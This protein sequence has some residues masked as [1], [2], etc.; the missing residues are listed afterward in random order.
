MEGVDVKAVAQSSDD[1]PRQNYMMRVM[2]PV[3]YYPQVSPQK[4]LQMGASA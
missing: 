3:H 4:V 1:W 2:R